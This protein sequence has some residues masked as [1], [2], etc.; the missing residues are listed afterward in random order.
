[1]VTTAERTASLRHNRNWQLYWLATSVSVVGDS[2]FDI[3]IML[4]VV[5]DVARGRSW[6]PAAASGVL[7]AAAVPYLLVGPAAGVYVDRWNRRRIMLTADACRMALIASLL[8]LPVISHSI[9]AAVQLAIIY[10]VLATE[11]CFAQFFNPC[12]LAVLGLVVSS[13]EL[14]RASGQIQAAIGLANVVGPPL[15]GAALFAAGVQWALIIDAASFAAS[16]LAIRRVR[17]ASW[18]SSMPGA[19]HANFRA[20]FREGLRFFAA[21]RI[22]LTVCAAVTIATIGTGALNSVEVFFVTRNLHSAASWLGYIFA[23]YGIGSIIGNLL[24]GKLAARGGTSRLF[25]LSMVGAGLTLV[26][27]SRTTSFPPAAV[28]M[29]ACGITIGVANA[30]CA[31]LI[32][33]ATPQHL[34]GRMSAV[35]NPVQQLASIASIA[36]AGLLASTALKN[37]HLVVHGITFG[38]I[39]TIIGVSGVFIL[40][41][42][43]ASFPALRPQPASNDHGDRVP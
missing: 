26:A 21:N 8:I 42:G 22:V 28:I 40:G 17:L 39:D 3:T 23:A 5:T 1:M 24:A 7:L 37:M 20:E 32:L 9:T 25:S 2:F 34:I 15:A 19:G 38:P 35:F 31:P 43:L 13:P 36:A 41:A 4:W 30:L 18:G 12:R 33:A 16:F 27:F 11:S 10:S 14:P 29:A 6:A